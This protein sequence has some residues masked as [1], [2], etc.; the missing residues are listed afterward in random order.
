MLLAL[1]DRSVICTKVVVFSGSFEA[2]G[3]VALMVSVSNSEH[4]KNP[5]K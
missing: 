3:F 2:S 5:A 1:I 4:Y